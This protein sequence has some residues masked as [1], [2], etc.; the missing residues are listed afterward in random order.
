ME[1]FNGYYERVMEEARKNNIDTAKIAG[2]MR[3]Q[4]ID[5]GVDVTN[6][7]DAEVI[8]A[9]LADNNIK[10]GSAEF[11]EIADKAYKGSRRLYERNNALGVGEAISDLTYILPL[12]GV[13]QIIKGAFKG[14]G[15][16]IRKITP[17][18]ITSALDKRFQTGLNVAAAGAIARNKKLMND[19]SDYLIGMGIRGVSEATEEGSQSILSDQYIRGLYDDEQS[20]AT[21]FDA[22][23]DGQVFKDMFDNAWFRA[24]SLGAAMGLDDEYKDDK[25]MAEE[26]LAGFLMSWTNPQGAI[27]SSAKAISELNKLSKLPKVSKYLEKALAKQDFINRNEEYFRNVREGLPSGNT[28]NEALDLIADELKSVGPDGTTRKYNLDVTVITD[29]QNPASNEQIDDFIKQ[30][31]ELSNS[32][33]AYRQSMLKKMKSMNLDGEDQDLYLSL[34]YVAKAEKETV[35]DSIDQFD[36]FDDLDNLSAGRDKDFTEAIDAMNITKD[37]L[38]EEEYSQIKRIIT[39][40]RRL[41]HIDQVMSQFD[42]NEK[43]IQY[44]KDKKYITREY[45]VEEANGLVGYVKQRQEIAKELNQAIN[46]LKKNHTDI[47]E[48][49]LRAL[50]TTTANENDLFNKINAAKYVD[51]KVYQDMLNQKSDAFQNPTEEFARNRI[52]T[53]RETRKRQAR[54]AD[55]ANQA[56]VTGTEV[57][58][59]TIATSEVSTDKV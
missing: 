28:W 47:D 38:S 3:Q 2:N 23:S 59:S 52:N 30:Q 7:T 45:A 31:K 19:I 15:K 20:N 14:M 39:L 25:Q 5:R 11:N 10:S 17:N 35:D 32:L 58:D 29:G 16:G 6:L 44:L 12:P 53:Y 21:F 13:N 36:K 51:N 46:N 24:R 37:E 8:Q 55:E 27:I 57:T 33:Y 26:M 4:F 18:V 9:G 56:A 41:D 43:V 34:A 49:D 54:L 1:A 40:N 48:V 22:V 50:D 42:S